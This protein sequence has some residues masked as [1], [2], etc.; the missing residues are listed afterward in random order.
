MIQKSFFVEVVQETMELFSQVHDLLT[1]SR[2]I[3]P[4]GN[5]FKEM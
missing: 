3:D 1:N 2:I 4:V 5:R